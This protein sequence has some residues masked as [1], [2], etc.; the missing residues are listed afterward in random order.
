MEETNQNGQPGE[1]LAIPDQHWQVISDRGT[2]D[3]VRCSGA[4]LLEDGSFQLEMLNRRMRVDVSRRLVDIDRQ[5]NWLPAPPL[6][7][8]VAVVYLA[9]S[10][11]VPLSGRWVSE[12]DLSCREFFRGPHEMRTELVLTRFGNNSVDFLEAARVYGGFETGDAGD[13]AVRLWV[14]PAIPL[15]LILWCGDEELEPALTVM[16]DESIDLLLPGD[17]IWALVQMVCEVLAE[18]SL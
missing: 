11:S 18:Q 14:F 1:P 15:K 5:G 8:F 4:T 12:K 2:E 17:G 16:F 7:A 6:P 3:I 10:R 13:A 9:N